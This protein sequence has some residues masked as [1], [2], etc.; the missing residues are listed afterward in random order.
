MSKS[1]GGNRVILV[2]RPR[3]EDTMVF[4]LFG[5]KSKTR[6]SRCFGKGMLVQVH[7]ACP[8]GVA[9]TAHLPYD[10]SDDSHLVDGGICPYCKTY[11][12]AWEYKID[13]MGSPM[14]CPHCDGKGIR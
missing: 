13:R 7:R 4:N 10:Q 5:S 6:C 8:K 9:S 2:V 11:F 3:H 1:L 14:I 12:D